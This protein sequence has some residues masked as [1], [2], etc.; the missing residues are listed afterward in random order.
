MSLQVLSIILTVS[1]LE[2]LG[3][4]LR[5]GEVHHE[6]GPSDDRAEVASACFLKGPHSYMVLY[7]HIHIYIYTSMLCIY[8]MHV[9]RSQYIH[10][11]MYLQRPKT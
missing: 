2:T 3:K 1:H 6:P 7:I 9:Y 5:H 10:I 4:H 8:L 11:C